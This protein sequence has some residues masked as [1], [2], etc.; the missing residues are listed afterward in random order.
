M[1]AQLLVFSMVFVVSGFKGLCAAEQR[2]SGRKR[3]LSERDV[4]GSCASSS[5]GGATKPMFT[6]DYYKDYLQN[7]QPTF[8]NR[9]AIEKMMGMTLFDGLV[10]SI[11]DGENR[12]R[13]YCK[14]AGFQIL[15]QVDRVS[16][17]TPYMIAKQVDNKNAMKSIERISKSLL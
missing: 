5:L 6:V 15:Q 11:E 1:K 17:L 16:G 8:K 3:S 7:E 10:G 4:H 13:L 12:V 9:V 14:I 2:L